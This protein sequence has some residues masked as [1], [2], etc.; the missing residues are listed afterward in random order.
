MRLNVSWVNW[1]RDILAI[2]FTNAPMQCVVLNSGNTI[3][4][5]FYC[6]CRFVPRG[7]GARE[8]GQ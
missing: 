5:L 7:V 8:G 6:C 2:P 1:C 4:K 3:W